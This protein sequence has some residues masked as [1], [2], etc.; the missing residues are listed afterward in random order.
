VAPLPMARAVPDLL[1][2]PPALAGQA[3]PAGVQGIPDAPHQPGVAN[4]TIT[5]QGTHVITASGNRSVLP[6][7]VA[8]P[9]EATSDDPPVPP[10]APEGVENVV[11]PPGGGMSPDV[12]EALARRSTDEPSE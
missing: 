11:L 3:P 7:G 4:V 8:V 1:P 9:A 6:P 2:P 5:P 12:A 10:E